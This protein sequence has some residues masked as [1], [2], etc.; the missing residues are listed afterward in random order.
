[1]TVPVKIT[2][3]EH[4]SQDLRRMA[5]SM[6]DTGH[7]RRLQAIS[8]VLDGWP[9]SRAAEFADVDRQTLCDWVGRYNEGGVGAL[10]IL[11]SPGR[12]RLLTQKQ[13]E[14]IHTIVEKGPDLDKDGVV[15]WRRVDLVQQ[16]AARFSVPEVHPS[17]MGEWLHRL[18]LTK[19]TTRPHHP[20]KDETAQQAF[21]ENFKD[22]V[23]EKLP[24]EV[25]ENGN[26]VEFWF[27]ARPASGSKAR[28][29]GYGHRS[30][31]ARRWC[32]TTAVQTPITTAPYARATASAQ[33]SLW[34]VPTPKL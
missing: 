24:A 21:E 13:D 30:A 7:A 16:S 15:R 10:A 20:K 32:G 27:Q 22:I 4:T 1:M 28:C 26:P 2:R 6:K 25:K 34:Q 18:G 12:R 29:R 8:I 11:T 23:N 31:R 14:E 5:A 9:R 3:E 33:L 19:L 17:T